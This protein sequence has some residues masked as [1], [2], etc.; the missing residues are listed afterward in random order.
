[1][2][3]LIE[4]KWTGGVPSATKKPLWFVVA[5][6]QIWLST[7]SFYRNKS[8]EYWISEAGN[9]WRYWYRNGYRVRRC[10]IRYFIEPDTRP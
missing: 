10:R 6:Q 3:K 4:G 1:M 8:I 9:D 2:A 7:A 5:P